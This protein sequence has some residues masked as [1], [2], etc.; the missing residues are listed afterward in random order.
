VCNSALPGSSAEI[1]D[2]TAWFSPTYKNN[3]NERAIGQCLV[4][5]MTLCA[6]VGT[7]LQIS[8]HL[9]LFGDLLLLRLLL[10]YD[11]DRQSMSIDRNQ[12]YDLCVPHR[13]SSSIVPPRARHTAPNNLEA[14]PR[15][16][17]LGG[18][19][20]SHITAT[21][22]RH[23]RRTSRASHAPQPPWVL[24]LPLRRT[25]FHVENASSSAVAVSALQ[26]AARRQV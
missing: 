18:F 6:R 22:R 17:A 11:H 19:E 21:R 8:R 4:Q 25:S 16:I 24:L 15:S 26:A 7:H 12:T 13:D 9:W 14:Y 5:S 3:K 2:Q 20:I 23:R 1:A 10:L